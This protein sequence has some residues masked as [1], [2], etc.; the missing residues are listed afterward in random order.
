[1]SEWTGSKETKALRERVDE[2]CDSLRKDLTDFAV[3]DAGNSVE[4][5]GLRTVTVVAQLSA[6]ELLEKYIEEVDDS[7]SG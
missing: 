4:Q 6:L 7:S 3:V 5:V 2:Y 1:M